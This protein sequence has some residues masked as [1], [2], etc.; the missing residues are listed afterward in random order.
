MLVIL[1]GPKPC[2]EALSS[3][4]IQ[5]RTGKI[6]LNR[7]LSQ[8]GKADDPWCECQNAYQTVRHII[9]DCPN[10]RHQ[11]L[12]YLKSRVIREYKLIL[13]QPEYSKAVA[14]FMVATGLLDQFRYITDKQS[15]LNEE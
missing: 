13:S 5:M 12:R 4:L 8:I 14:Q 2:D 10:F 7:Y 3:I 15:G 11:R 6:G 1:T 9:E